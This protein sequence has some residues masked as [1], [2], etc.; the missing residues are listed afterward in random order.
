[1]IIQFCGLSGSGKTTLAG[2]I[3]CLLKERNIAA[4]ILDGDV[5]R[6]IFYA[7]LGFSREERSSHIRH[8]AF[9]AGRFS[10]HHIISII[11]AIN[12]FENIRREVA[13]RYPF[14][15]TVF[16][17]CP[18]AVLMTRDTKNLYKKAMLPDDHPD[19]IFNLSGV[20]DPFE[21]PG[22]PDLVIKTD[23]ESVE[24]SS[25]RLL[26]FILLHYTTPRSVPLS[27]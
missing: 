2:R 24:T 21:A 19:K 8:L 3:H 9:L 1:M 4:E 22:N 26:Q 6:K 16:I 11:S 10:E 7:G 15:K 20:N 5:Y 13:L 18:V 17:D 12:P 23:T 27:F 25:G 14:V